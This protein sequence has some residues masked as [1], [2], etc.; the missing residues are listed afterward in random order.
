MELDG[1]TQVA[2]ICASILSLALT[3]IFAW[4]TRLKN[5]H[6]SFVAA[7]AMQTFWLLNIGL[8]QNLNLS[9]PHLALIEA[10]HFSAWII[11]ITQ[12]IT[13][14]CQNCLP[15]HYK[16][17]QYGFCFI[18]LVIDT[19][20]VFRNPLWL[21][22]TTWMTLQNIIFAI[23]CLLSI[24]QLYRNVQSV[25]LIKL[26]CL[27]LAGV[28]IYDIYFFSQS[29]VQPEL[30]PGFFQIR[31][32]IVIV[33]SVFMS[34]AAISLPQNQDQPARLSLSRPVVFYTTSLTLAGSLL[35]I[36]SLGGY[37]VRI[38]G[39]DWGAVAYG[40]L[41]SAAMI[42]LALAI[43]SRSTREMLTV[44]INKHLFSHKYDY[45]SEWLKLIARLSQPTSPE[46]IHRHAIDAVANIFKSDGGALWLRRGRVFAPV[47]QENV[48]LNIID[49][50]E[51]EDS[52]FIQALER[53]EWVFLP[54]SSPNSDN[55]LSQ[56]NEH[57]PE[58]AKTIDNIWLILP[59]LNES[60][61]IGFMVLTNRNNEETLNWEDLD[62]L[63]TVGR[64]VANYIERHEQAEQLAEARQFDAFNKLAA[65]VM[66]DLKNLIA[67]QSLV[68]KN[69]EKHKD[70]PAFVDDAI[71]TINNS[72]ARMNTL[73]RKLQRNEPE[74]IRVLN[75]NEVLIEAIKRCQ[76][77]SPR[78]TL[79]NDYH[80]VRVKGDWDS[81]VMVF[82]HLIHNAQDATQDS[83]FIDVY[84]EREAN[85]IRVA[86]ED[87]GEGMTPEFIRDRLFKPFD[88]TKTGKGMGI[89]VYQARDYLQALGGNICVASTPNEG[90]T[91]TVSL[92]V[93]IS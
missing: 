44:L 8:S 78:P 92:P 38:Y 79:R 17:A 56:Y 85:V 83:G 55:P 52:Q 71:Q 59:L 40:L 37:Y 23:V 29:L 41:L 45:R 2:Y 53:S 70:N 77:A 20:Y 6:W 58:W 60:K 18:V 69:A 75:L 62:L 74:G 48:A 30:N 73:L 67:Q 9:L 1:V 46:E 12:S 80:E 76:K 61:L 65:Y 93:T 64:Q 3:G 10:A 50:I 72:V 16:S 4:Q 26:L 35:A 84:V 33:T 49:V 42:I 19:A 25:R 66:H 28:F 36:I 21:P 24:E 86:I 34:I 15:R 31:A 87:N 88:T 54:S 82:V 43:T 7:S 39:G 14:F 27:N 57:L 68:V 11:A 5:L 13:F 89:G 63:K 32:A 90:S 81:L 22:I 47:Y 51:S 91:F